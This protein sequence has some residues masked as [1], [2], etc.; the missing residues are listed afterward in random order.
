VVGA[1]NAGTL[2]YLSGRRVVNLDGVVNSWQYF[3]T[4][5]HDLCAYWRA[6]GVTYLVD[7]FENGRALSVVP[8]HSAY[9]RCAHGLE[10]VWSDGRYGTPWRME[11]YRVH[12]APP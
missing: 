5:R 6:V 8:T 9:A 7:A 1:W 4:E 12:P 11:A 10:R 3:R 2:G